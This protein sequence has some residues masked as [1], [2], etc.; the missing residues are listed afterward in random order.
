MKRKNSTC[1]ALILIIL[2][3]CGLSCSSAD[4]SDYKS[5]LK[6]IRAMIDTTIM[7]YGDYEALVPPEIYCPG[8]EI[9]YIFAVP[10]NNTIGTNELNN[11]ITLL[12]FKNSE[13]LEQHVVKKDFMEM[14]TGPFDFRF[15]PVWSAKEIA[16]SQS[17]GFLLVNLQDKKVEIH[18][19]SPGMYAGDI[20]NV[21]V[22][23]GAKRTFVL[24]VLS[25]NGNDYGENWDDKTLKVIQFSNDTFS[26]LAEHP[27]GKKTSAYTEPWFVYDK[28]IFIFNDSTTKLE[29]FDEQFKSV[30]HP[31]AES[32]NKNRV[33]FRSMQEIV[34]HPTLPFALIVEQG[35]PPTKDKLNAADALP[36]SEC[37]KARSLIYGDFE[38]KTLYLFRWTEPDPKKQFV[39]LLSV[40]GSIW[41][42]YNPTNSYSDFTFSPDGKWVIF[43]DKTEGSDNPIFVTVPISTNNTLYLGKPIKLGKVLRQDAIGPKGTAWT[44]N[45]TAFVMSDG[46][47]LY[48]WNMDDIPSVERVKMTKE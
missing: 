23:D 21:A 44:T 30:N 29:V 45:P 37:D 4:K 3:L 20:E 8:E 25:S 42:S 36:E 5:K 6:E 15:L 34:I 47:M 7:D 22:I 13:E 12:E 39:P 11:A 40:A 28:K 41:N 1:L 27:A 31:I 9:R 18:T 10:K 38:R 24:E 32:F 43:R 26:V 48:R 14:V 16:Y 17:K 46:L 33:G 2:F 35:K 19:I